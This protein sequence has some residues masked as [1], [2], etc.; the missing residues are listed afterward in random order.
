MSI[1]SHG[2]H[3]ESDGSLHMVAIVSLFGLARYIFGCF[4][5]WRTKRLHDISLSL[6]LHGLWGKY[7]RME[8]PTDLVSIVRWSFNHHKYKFGTF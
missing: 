3:L 5:A 4:G 8:L 2:H 1:V 6:A 7:H